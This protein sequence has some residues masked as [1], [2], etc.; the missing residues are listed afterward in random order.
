MAF[1]AFEF[2]GI[3]PTPPTSMVGRITSILDAFEARQERLGLEELIHRTG[4]PRSTTHR[5][6][7]QLE[8]I[9]WIEHDSQGYSLGHRALLSPEPQDDQSRLRKIVAPVLQD[10]HIRTG[11]VAHLCTLSGSEIVFVDKIG[12]AYAANLPSDVGTR[13]WVTNSCIGKAILATLSPEQADPIVR[14]CPEFSAQDEHDHRDRI[15]DLHRQLAVIRSRNNVAIERGEGMPEVGAVACAI[16]DRERPTGAISLCGRHETMNFTHLAR[17]VTA[18]AHHAATQ[19]SQSP[20]AP[21]DSDSSPRHQKNLM[22]NAA[23]A[24]PGWWWLP[25]RYLADNRP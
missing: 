17:L 1:G 21:G 5:I 7:D 14:E 9:G 16:P 13:W 3:E 15:G 12:G 22:Y 20:S 8:R 18:A 10:L 24:R 19:L 25:E 6:L 23:H 2:D 11:L 4:L